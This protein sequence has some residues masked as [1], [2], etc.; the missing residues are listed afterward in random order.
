MSTRL[1]APSASSEGERL[2]GHAVVLGHFASDGNNG[3][4]LVAQ[5]GHGLLKADDVDDGPIQP[6]PQRF[7]GMQRP[8]EVLLCL[9]RR[10]NDGQFRQG[11]PQGGLKPH[12]VGD[13]VKPYPDLS[14]QSVQRVR[15]RSRFVVDLLPFFGQIFA[16]H[17]G[18]TVAGIRINIFRKP[19]GAGHGRTRRSLTRIPRSIHPK[20]IP[21]KAKQTSD[22][23]HH[24][25]T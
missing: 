6:L 13:A 23:Q 15:R 4:F 3:R 16:L 22:D 20:A 5:T 11:T 9:P 8:F 14:L 7:L 25:Q 17:Q 2:R 1:L 12:I 10:G 21:C 24:N 19:I 18:Q